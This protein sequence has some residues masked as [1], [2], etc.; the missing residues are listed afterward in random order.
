MAKYIKTEQGY[1]DASIFAPAQFK[2][3]GKSYL[4]FSSPK[5]F[6]LKVGDSTKHWNGILEYFSA[7]KVWAVWDGTT[8]LSA[9]NNDG[10]YVLYLRGTGNTVITGRTANGA[11]GTYRWVLTGSDIACVGNIENLLD[12][13]TV[14]SGQHPTMA[15]A[16]YVYMF[17][18]CTSLTQAPTLTATTLADYCYCGMFVR[19]TSLTQAPV[20]PAI[21]LSKGCYQDMFFGCTSLTQAPTLTATTLAD[22]CYADMFYGCTSLTQAPALSATTLSSHCYHQMFSSCTSLT[23]TPA[24]PATTLADWCYYYMFHDCT[25]LTKAPALPATTLAKNC[26]YGMFSGCTSLTQ[27]P[28]LPATTLVNSCYQSMFSGCTSLKLSS[29]KTGEYTVAYRIPTTGVGSATLQDVKNM[30]FSTGGTFT[31]AP[32]INTTYYLSTDNMI[33][34]DTEV[35]TLNGYVG[36]MIDSASVQPDWNQN[37]ET[38]ADYVK[39]R[40][41]YAGDPVETVLVEE[42]TATFTENNGLYGVEFKSPFEATVGETYKVYWDGAAYECTCAN[43]NEGNIPA[44]GNLS[45]IGAGSDTGEP[46]LMGVNN[47][48]GISIVAADTSASHTFSISGFVPGVIKIDEK[49]LPELPYMD[50]ESP[51]ATGSFSLNRRRNTIVGKNSFTEGNS[52]TASGDT[53]HAE[54]HFTTASG[55]FSHAEGAET[56]ALGNNSHAEGSGTTA[57]G[58]S[59]HAEGCQ[60]TALGNNSHAEGF[61]LNKAPTTITSS[62]TNDTIINAWKSE[63][64]TLAKG[65]RSH[66]EGENV[67]A[68]DNNSHAEGYQTTASSNSSHAEGRETKASGKYSHAEGYTTIASGQSSHTEG[69]GTQ[70]YGISSHAEGNCT[71]AFKDYSHTEGNFTYARSE[72]Q[73]VQGKYNI[74][75]DSGTYA[76]IVGNGTAHTA[77]SNAH[78]LDWSGN[79]W[80]AGTI[81]GKALILP[82]STK[83]STKRFKITVDDSGTL[84][85]TEIT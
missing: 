14:E 48:N 4:T 6:T 44:I 76:H 18:D 43:F 5:D 62:S 35:A 40:P 70:A 54:G 19:C 49:Y 3:E 77:R 79:A 55:K 41:F 20:L 23:Q 66:A 50:K 30:F 60:T 58:D 71:I 37:D 61:S 82:S 28:A 17:Y 67:L 11:S 9:Y 31:A 13:A 16:C 45:I 81:E 78:T 46:F 34:R 2:P 29:T 51:T 65:L 73:H 83:G 32:S 42:S 12:Y 47:G 75:D 52:T 27:V 36:S 69:N 25:S 74:E 59:S 15:E 1:I 22:Y 10:E 84:T 8:I 38:A 80:F 57:S 64:F 68:L 85:A 33:V 39:N 53:S 56:T 21:T 7:D 26:Y 63:K 72:N 24:L